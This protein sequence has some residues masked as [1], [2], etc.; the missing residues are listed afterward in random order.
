MKHRHAPDD[1]SQTPRLLHAVR[2]VVPSTDD[3]T[4]PASNDNTRPAAPTPTSTCSGGTSPDGARNV[5][6]VAVPGDV[7][8]KPPLVI[9]TATRESVFIACTNNAETIPP[10]AHRCNRAHLQF[11]LHRLANARSEACATF[12]AG[13]I[14]G[15]PRDDTR[16]VCPQRQSDAASATSA[17][18]RAVQ[19]L[20]FTLLCRRH[21]VVAGGAHP[22]RA[23][24]TGISCVTNT[25]KDAVSVPKPIV[26]RR[27]ARQLSRQARL[28]HGHAHAVPAATRP[29]NAA[30]CAP[31]CETIAGNLNFHA[32]ALLS[33]AAPQWP[34]P[35]MHMPVALSHAPAFEHSAIASCA[36]SVTTTPPNHCRP[37]GHSPAR[38]RKSQMA[39]Q[40]RAPGQRPA[41]HGVRS[42]GQ[43]SPL[44]NDTSPWPDRTGRGKCSHQGRTVPTKTLR[45]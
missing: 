12:R 16:D 45:G 44:R 6:D 3:P 30:N 40:E 11:R 13:A 27:R 7:E 17:A 4:P 20:D 26:A 19:H 42:R 28:T 2:S 15:I 35:Q 34:A 14:N 43:R 36:I 39:I 29:I 23:V 21:R 5:I 9:E 32:H 22:L 33:Q 8:H 10:E 24:C 18:A 1:V 37:K 38:P 31:Y 41:T 25:P